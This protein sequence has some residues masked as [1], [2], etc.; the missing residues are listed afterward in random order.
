MP[1]AWFVFAVGVLGIAVFSCMDAM[2]KHLVLTVGVYTTLLW[3]S[4]ASTVISGGLYAASRPRGLTRA[5]VRVHL[6]RGAVSTVSTVTFFWGLARVPL[7]QAVALTFIAPLLSIFLA[8][9]LLGERLRPRALAASAI[10]LAGVV[11]ILLGQWRGSMGVRALL[12]S[13]AILTSALCY[14]YNIVLMRRQALLA[15]PLEIAF[16][17]SAIVALLLACAAPFMG[18]LAVGGH[19]PLIGLAAS[20]AV[21]SLALLAWAYARGEASRLSSGEYTA[22]IWAS[23]LGWLF[24]HERVT[25]LT[26]AGAA[27]IVAGCALAAGLRA[28]PAGMEIGI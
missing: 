25:P 19:A 14:A 20:L 9:G 4:L 17:Q 1:P 2:M 28:E 5:A 26:V 8:A 16:S 12:G 13:G 21:L 15:G 7:A 6:V 22:F 10:A 3:R 18:S 27:L 24:F 11:V 23:G